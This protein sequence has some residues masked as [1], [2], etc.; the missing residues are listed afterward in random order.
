MA[1]QVTPTL[2]KANLA[3]LLQQSGYMDDEKFNIL[4]EV[5]KKKEKQQLM[6]QAEE[7]VDQTGVGAA[8][9]M[10]DVNAQVRDIPNQVQS[11]D[12]EAL[13]LLKQVIEQQ[14][15]NK[16]PAPEMK[17]FGI[18]S[19][20]PANYKTR[21]EAEK[22]KRELEGGFVDIGEK[23]TAMTAFAKLKEEDRKGKEFE[24]MKPFMDR[25]F[26][27][28]GI[29]STEGLD[30]SQASAA[31]EAIGFD[32]EIKNISPA[33]ATIDFDTQKEIVARSMELGKEFIK[34]KVVDEY[35]TINTQVGTMDSLLKNALSG[36]A[37]SMVAIDQ[38]LITTFNK[39][40]DPTSV[41]RESEYA[42]TT[43]DLS[44]ENRFKGALE[45][46]NKGGAGLTNMDRQA[47][48]DGAKVIANSRGKQFNDAYDRY[49][50]IA[51][52][53]KADGTIVFGDMKQHKEL[54]TSYQIAAEKKRR[55][56]K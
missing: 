16:S 45:K 29:G 41:V 9:A 44:L 37:Q 15:A 36:D 13:A 40:N 1:I 30:P 26:K 49:G 42:R 55:G 25:A 33:G 28:S 38:A 21:L 39:I 19:E 2:D 32:P 8:K 7:F 51:K 3:Q 50:K 14:N 56:I 35:R 20:T 11:S 46:L 27:K 24:Q 48:V 12:N 6:S 54:Y 22:L 43:G 17:K 18:F 31:A 23:A 10:L 34:D 5:V 4:S 52:K 47:L 53:A